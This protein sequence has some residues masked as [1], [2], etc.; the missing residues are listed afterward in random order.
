MWVSYVITLLSMDVYNGLP[1][2]T[3][4]GHRHFL[5]LEK[6][7]F[8]KVMLWSRQQVGML[9]R[10]SAT[11]NDVQVIREAF[12]TWYR[13][14]G[15]LSVCWGRVPQHSR[16]MGFVAAKDGNELQRLYLYE[17]VMHFNAMRVGKLVTGY[18]PP[19]PFPI[20]FGYLRFNWGEF[21]FTREVF[22]IFRLTY[23][24]ARVQYARTSPSHGD[25]ATTSSTFSAD[26]KKLLTA[27]ATDH[28]GITPDTGKHAFDMFSFNNE[29]L[30]GKSHDQSKLRRFDTLEAIED[31]GGNPFETIEDAL[32]NRTFGTTEANS[33][34]SLLHGDH[35]K[36]MDTWAE[37]EMSDLDIV[38]SWMDNESYRWEAM[39]EF[40]N[41][42]PGKAVTIF[43][44]RRVIPSSPTGIT[45]TRIDH[46]ETA[47]RTDLRY[48]AYQLMFAE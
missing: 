46:Y 24:Y 10:G 29:G 38:L 9:G 5:E 35:E 1:P 30:T 16:D 17:S 11:D 37:A 19:Q 20:N 22:R 39:R 2:G 42:G 34:L 6:I 26:V 41:S 45:K 48:K 47:R 31:A 21:A 43:G 27:M 8:I 4:T 7:G 18:T 36:A 3:T 44:D 23:Q 12:Q 13:N 40:F 15:N 32:L 25:L 28:F 33:M 14:M